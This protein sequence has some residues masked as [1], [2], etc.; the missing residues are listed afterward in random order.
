M[1]LGFG[2]DQSLYEKGHG[3]S[4][5]HI[6]VRGRR[7]HAGICS[8]GVLPARDESRVLSFPIVNLHRQVDETA[9]SGCGI[10][11]FEISHQALRSYCVPEFLFLFWGQGEGPGLM[12]ASAPYAGRPVGT[13]HRHLIPLD[14][15]G[16]GLRM[17]VLALFEIRQFYPQMGC[18]YGGQA[19]SGYEDKQGYSEDDAEPK[20]FHEVSHQ[21]GSG[22]E[23]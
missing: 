1:L 9:Y 5:R 11:F 21:N 4:A 14:L 7:D 3:S 10:L 15:N 18:L 8:Q 22:F 19:R 2:R 23:L 16:T 12:G 13:G 17:A 6:P 20:T